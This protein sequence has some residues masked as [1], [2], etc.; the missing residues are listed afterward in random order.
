MTD[1]RHQ[2]ETVWQAILSAASLLD[3]AGIPYT[4]EGTAALFAQG[5]RLADK[6][7]IRFSVQ[8][9]LLEK[10]KMIFSGYEPSDI[11]Q[12]G[13]EHASFDFAIEGAAVTI[14]GYYRAV[15][16]TDPDRLAIDAGGYTLWVKAFDSYLRTLDKDDSV[17]QAIKKRLSELQQANTRQNGAAWN[18]E[19]YQAWIER[20]GTPAEAAEKLRRDPN[21]RIAQLAPYLGDIKGKKVIN[22]LGSHGGKALALALLGASATVVDISEENA[23]YAKETAAALGIDL[24]YVVSDVLQLPADRRTADYDLVL[25]E[26]GILHYFVDLEPLAELVRDLLK[27]GGRLVLQDFHPV[28]TKLIT[29]TGKKQK[30]T[31]NYFENNGNPPRGLQQAFAG[32][33]RR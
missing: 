4:L 13:K 16:R 8:W 21:G 5:V 19:A 11:I 15:V 22:L 27:A 24:D 7:T 1:Y 29:L 26:L 3:Q 17:R 14:I 33:R 10:A 30:V 2:D 9:D 20:F 28:S 18:Q 32:R 23:A 12:H 31:G 6:P 25:M